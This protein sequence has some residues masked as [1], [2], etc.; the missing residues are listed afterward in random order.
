MEPTGV[1][2]VRPDGFIA[3]RSNDFNGDLRE[4]LA[5]MLCQT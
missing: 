3:W 2:L 1:V 4:A 5:R